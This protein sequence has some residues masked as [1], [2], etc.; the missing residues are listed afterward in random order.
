MRMITGRAGGP[1]GRWA[2]AARR[3]WSGGGR[4]LAAGRAGPAAGADRP[5]ASRRQPGRRAGGRPRLPGRRRR[6]GVRLVAAGAAGS[7]R[8][9]RSGGAERRSGRAQLTGWQV[10]GGPERAVELA[11]VDGRARLGRAQRIVVGRA[12]AGRR[13]RERGVAERGSAGIGARIALAADDLAEQRAQLVAG[14]GQAVGRRAAGGPAGRRVRTA[15]GGR[16][17]WRLR[18]RA[19][20]RRGGRLRSATRPAPRQWTRPA[21]DH[22]ARRGRRPGGAV[23]VVVSRRPSAGVRQRV[24]VPGRELVELGRALDRP[25]ARSAGRRAGSPLPAA[26]PGRSPMEPAVA[27]ARRGPG[28]ARPGAPGG[29]AARAG[30][31]VGDRG[32]VVAQVGVLRRPRRRAR[33]TA[34]ALPALVGRRLV[35]RPGGRPQ[36]VA[37]RGGRRSRPTTPRPSAGCRG[38]GGPTGRARPRAPAGR[39]ARRRTGWQPPPARRSG[40]P[41]ANGKIV[42]GGRSG[43]GRWR[44]ARPSGAGWPRRRPDRRASGR[45]G[46]ARR[47]WRRQGHRDA[48]GAPRGRRRAGE[49]VEVEHDRLGHG[50][51]GAALHVLEQP[52]HLDRLL[53][54]LAG[55]GR[56]RAARARPRGPRGRSGRSIARHRHL[57]DAQQQR[58]VAVGHLGRLLLRGP[59][60]EQGV[61]RRGQRVDV[62]GRGHLGAL[63]HLGRGVVAHR[64]V[65]RAQP[66]EHGERGQP[67]LDQQGLAVG[68]EHQ[69]GGL[70]VAVHDAGPV[71]GLERPGEQHAD[72]ER[73]L[74]RRAGRPW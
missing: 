20:R 73:P 68:A 2:A 67:G 45:A 59:A 71:G 38:G 18:R 24:G 72:L 49:V 64:V 10:R 9:R 33:W 22:G 42:G 35:G 74:D 6:P 12:V 65:E 46:G 66:G 34:T 36:R 5:S 51:A 11:E 56:Q 32:G 25:R 53:G 43:S 17:R 26:K 52:R 28:R 29:T 3:R 50:H 62:G 37:G 40:R 23:P 14:A 15:G 63:E 54:P 13:R 39:L 4:D 21:S 47:E 27:A 16:R 69:P 19:V 60:R 41:S 7:G 58:R 8:P 57:Q 48:G 44:D 31:V 1:A 30:L 61:D 70:Q 55:A